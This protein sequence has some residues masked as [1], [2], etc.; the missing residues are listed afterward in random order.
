MRTETAKE[1]AAEEK[2]VQRAKEDE[3]KAQ[4]EREA[5]QNSDKLEAQDKELHGEEENLHVRCFKTAEAL[6]SDAGDKL[7]KSVIQ[8]SKI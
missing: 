3:E 4:K 1:E 7:K 5:K 8:Y 2:V 6:V